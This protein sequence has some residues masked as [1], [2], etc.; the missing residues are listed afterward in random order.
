MQCQSEKKIFLPKVLPGLIALVLGSSL[1]D[2]V[3]IAAIIDNGTVQLGI[4]DYGNLIV[5]G[6][7]PS[8]ETGTTLVGLRF[9]A[10]NAEGLGSACLCEGWGIGDTFTGINGYANEN[11]GGAFGLTLDSFSSTGTTAV[12]QVSL[13]NLLTVTHDFQPSAK[14]PYL[15]EIKITIENKSNLASNLRYRRVLDWDIDPTTFNEFITLQG[16]KRPNVLFASD[17]GFASANPF[18]GKSS[19]IF[20]GDEIDVGAY[21]G[22]TLFDL[23]FGLLQ[24][25]ASTT[26]AIFYGV[27]P[28]EIAALDALEKVNAK[29]YSFGQAN[30][31]NGA[32]LG[33]PNTFIFALNTEGTPP[34]LPE[35]DSVISLI[36]LGILG[37]IVT[38][39]Q[40][41]R[42]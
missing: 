33:T 14:T 27:A 31:P 35:T 6:N 42:K 22:G 25:Q 13:D 8:S 41:R 26:F 16:T 38:L 21:D 4:N 1:T 24:P 12:S 19:I 11:E 37:T 17:D 10:K 18:A 9:L 23:N 28:N 29:T 2:K 20:T 3:A 32:D 15:Y 36:G 5:S 34:P 30:V 39:K 7:E 40:S